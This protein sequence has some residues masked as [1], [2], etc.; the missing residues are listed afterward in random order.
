M[1]RKLGPVVL[2]VSVLWAVGSLA[3]K[4]GV[5]VSQ[6]QLS[7]NFSITSISAE[8]IHQSAV[9]TNPKLSAEVEKTC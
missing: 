4:G 8:I 5:G 9:C 3:I 1:A 7:L 2:A 6:A